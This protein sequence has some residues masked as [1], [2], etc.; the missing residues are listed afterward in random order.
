MTT[1]FILPV[2]RTHPIPT[3]SH[4][5]EDYYVGRVLGATDALSDLPDWNMGEFECAVRDACAFYECQDG[6]AKKSG[7]GVSGGSNK[8]L[9]YGYL[10]KFWVF[11]TW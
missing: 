8:Q 3:H 9:V 6:E 7:G 4:C 10:H 1:N 2:N 11:L 5:T